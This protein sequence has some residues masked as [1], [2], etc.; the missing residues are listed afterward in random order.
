[1]AV[2][3]APL[4]LENDALPDRAE[5]AVA[6]SVTCRYCCEDE[7]AMHDFAVVSSA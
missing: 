1:M 3:H 5:D 2:C 7:T 6:A 4:P